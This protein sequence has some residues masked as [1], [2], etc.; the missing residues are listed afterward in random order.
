[1]KTGHAAPMGLFHFTAVYYKH[2]A[3]NGAGAVAVQV[4]SR[5]SA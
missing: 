5:E 4:I 2:A 1:M 3:P